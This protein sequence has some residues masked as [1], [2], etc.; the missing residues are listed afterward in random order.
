MSKT[1]SQLNWYVHPSIIYGVVFAS[2]AAALMYELLWIRTL[3]L[4]FGV[5]SFAVTTVVSIF[6]LGL[7][8]G[9]YFFGR[10]TEKTPTPLR[11][12]A[13]IE[14][15]I[16]A[17]TGLSLVA[18]EYTPLFSGLHALIY[19]H[20]NLYILSLVRLLMTCVILFP[21]TFC[22]GG[23]VPILC[24]YFI[25]K[26]ETLGSRFT[27]LYLLN[28]LGGFTG[29]IAAGFITVRFFGT[30]ASYLMAIAMNVAI[31]FTIRA[32]RKISTAP[33]EKSE[34][35]AVPDRPE[36]P[37]R[38]M[39]LALFISGFIALGFEIVWIR[40]L[41][42]FGSGTTLSSTLILS[43]FLLGFAIGSVFV[44]RLIDRSKNVLRL[45]VACFI[46]LG[47]AATLSFLGFGM[48]NTYFP[49]PF[50]SYKAMLVESFVG[51][52]FS[53]VLA[54][55]MGTIFPLSVR[56][57]AGTAAMIGRKSGYAYFINSL[58]TVAGSIT[59]GFGLIPFVGIRNSGLVLISLCFLT[60]GYLAIRLI[61]GRRLLIGIAAVLLVAS[62]ASIMASNQVFH[63]LSAGSKELFYAEGLSATV[64]VQEI[65]M[66]SETYKT[67]NVDS[68]TVASTHHTGVVDSKLLAHIPL[69]LIDEPKRAVTVGYGSG[70][71]SHSMLQYGCEVIA[72]EI[73][74]QVIEASREFTDLNQH[75]ETNPKLQIIIDDAR[76]YL[77]NTETAFD[78]I[79]TDVTNLKYKSNPYLYTQE[80]FEAMRN[81]LA[82]DGVAAAWVPL[83][84][85][86]FSDLKILLKTFQ[87]VYP[88]TTVWYDYYDATGFLIITGTPEKMLFDFEKVHQRIQRATTDLE[89]IELSDVYSLG[90]F[91]LLGERDVK[92]LSAGSA[93]N[94]DDRPVL[95]FTDL[96]SYS[97]PNQFKNL[98][99]LL[100]SQNE[101]LESYYTFSSSDEEKILQAL[102]NGRTIMNG[103]ISG[104]AP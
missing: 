98:E 95:E 62:C 46:T 84:G 71:T 96:D 37:K 64:T 15:G 41:T 77:A 61:Q 14:L 13:W 58:G 34:D 76:N 69:M 17:L 35:H 27:L 22:L 67:L 88:H 49:D 56:L 79:V 5:S 100:A 78:A 25:K 83:G 28:T 39:G 68:E 6:L 91:L 97:R 59:A 36:P 73:E 2:G 93:V 21:A 60:A 42:N 29:A 19:N 43:G 12:Y 47:T 33:P 20:A 74:R 63:R 1:S 45:L 8:L 16:A 99:Q 50:I 89:S 85:L 75:A 38:N 102:H 54:I 53:F 82:P 32:C 30:T 52:G 24:K 40:V 101:I 80:Y 86:S 55:F 11:L 44:V 31:F 103:Y 48:L 104:I 65:T 3:N 94:T 18:V 4:L 66:L 90:S 9:G 72:L 57:Y 92:M 81:A 23:T 7:G 10:Q 70:G 87:T 26:D 51:F